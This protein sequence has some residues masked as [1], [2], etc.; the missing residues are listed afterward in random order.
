MSR[1]SCE[2]FEEH[3]S[4]YLDE[5]LDEKLHAQV[6]RHIEKCSKCRQALAELRRVA[7]W[8]HDL[9]RGTAPADLS[10]TLVARLEREQ[11]YGGLDALPAQPSIP[12]GAL[13]FGRLVASAAVI[14]LTVTAGYLTIDYVRQS[15]RAEVRLADAERIPAGFP[16][17]E[18][19]LVAKDSKTAPSGLSNEIAQIAGSSAPEKV[20]MPVPPAAPL[21]APAEAPM[22]MAK[23]KKAQEPSVAVPVAVAKFAEPARPPIVVEATATSRP[24]TGESR[25]LLPPPGG[26]AVGRPSASSPSTQKGGDVFREMLARAST[27]LFPSAEPVPTAAKPGRPAASQPTSNGSSEWGYG[28]PRTAGTGSTQ[29]VLTD[30]LDEGITVEELEQHAMDQEPVQLVLSANN[31][32]ER[33]QVARELRSFF[34]R[35]AIVDARSLGAKTPV[36]TASNFYMLQAVPSSQASSEQFLFRG[37]PTQVSTLVDEISQSRRSN[38]QVVLNTPALQ[39]NGWEKANQVAQMLREPPSQAVRRGGRSPRSRGEGGPAAEVAGHR[40]KGAPSDAISQD[41]RR[42]REAEIR[43]RWLGADKKADREGEMKVRDVSEP[44][45]PPPLP[46][47]QNVSTSRGVMQA[48]TQISQGLRV[49]QAPGV[50]QAHLTERASAK[51]RSSAEGQDHLVTVV[52]TVQAAR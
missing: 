42:N 32:A 16:S 3:L 35:N 34:A 39:A 31:A 51:A 1:R 40:A 10:E 37:T 26:V 12:P 2:Q 7:T 33:E 50:S 5:E 14:L 44:I 6:A 8:V 45:G 49:A 18:A 43:S 23:A 17:G 30:R 48:R 20:A 41:V 28:R 13:R 36:D 19:A 24:T 22:M 38:V 47:S 11:L 25:M 52:I 46:P 29:T 15:R 4:A 27:V 21:A 9:P